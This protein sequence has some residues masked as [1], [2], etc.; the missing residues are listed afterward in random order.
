[1]MGLETVLFII[2]LLYFVFATVTRGWVTAP[3][4]QMRKRQ[5]SQNSNTVWLAS[6]A[7]PTF[8][9]PCPTI[10]SIGHCLLCLPHFLRP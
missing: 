2:S 4:L 8:G 9:E 1:M 10:V 6:L 3:I 7:V 5:R